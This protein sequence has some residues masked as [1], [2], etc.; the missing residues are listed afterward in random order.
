MKKLVVVSLGGCCGVSFTIKKYYPSHYTLFDW[1]YTPEI[2]SVI[3]LIENNFPLEVDN[4]KSKVFGYTMYQ[5]KLKN[6]LFWLSHTNLQDLQRRLTRLNDI[7]KDKNNH[8][9]FIRFQHT[10]KTEQEQYMNKTT[11]HIIKN[12]EILDYNISISQCNRLIEALNKFVQTDYSII[13]DS[14]EEI[15]I[16]NK[17]PNIYYKYTTHE[18]ICSTFDPS[19]EKLITIK[20]ENI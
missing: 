18:H 1:N 15:P 12:D 11:K 9:V 13:I 8:I 5:E 6:Y 4:K 14:Q 17:H 16:E 10:K 19:Y 20:N 3:Q 7:C 2:E